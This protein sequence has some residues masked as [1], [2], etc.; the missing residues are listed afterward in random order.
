[1]ETDLKLISNNILNWYNF[2]EGT[3][4]LKI[5]KEY[6]IDNLVSEK[7]DYIILI[8]TLPYA[9]KENN[10][11]SKEFIKEISKLLKNTGKL[12]IAVDNKFAIRYFVGDSDEYL[13]KK[14]SVLLNYNN[15]LEKIETYT[16]QKLEKMLKEC[17]I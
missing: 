12:L 16:K 1:M 4:I 13:N 8:G 7:Y 15:E 3:N 6:K 11:T 9:A 5:D 14:F 10:M 2:E 17:R